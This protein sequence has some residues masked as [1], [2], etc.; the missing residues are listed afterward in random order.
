MATG[1]TADAESAGGEKLP[2]DTEPAE[3]K[4]AEAELDDGGDVASRDPDAIANEIEQTRAELAETIDAI[5]DRISP[6][7]AA[8]RS[9]QAVKAQVTSAKEKV[10]GDSATPA[11]A[12]SAPESSALTPAVAPSLPIGPI[13]AVAGAVLLI[14]VILRKRRS[15]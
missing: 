9:A 1:E 5:A 4:P 11:A 14:L 8:S 3:A 12:P 13:V 7:K 6:R 10:T 15:R 2:A